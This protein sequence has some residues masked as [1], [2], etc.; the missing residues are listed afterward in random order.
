M[1]LLLDTCTFLWLA[2]GDAA[3]SATARAAITTPD[4]DLFLSS[5]SAAEIAV[6]YRRKRLRLAAAPDRLVPVM[7]RRHRITKLPLTE[8]AALGV[9]RLPDLHRDPFDRLLIAQALAHGLVLVTPDEAIRRYPVP[10]L[11]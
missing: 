6:K 2:T 1:R 9:A 4:N 3:L 5:V 10:T 11:W 7:R 8:A